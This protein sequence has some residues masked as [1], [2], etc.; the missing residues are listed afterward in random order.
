MRA[1]P[2]MKP[3]VH[4]RKKDDEL[5]QGAALTASVGFVSLRFV[6][7]HSLRKYRPYG[8][9]KSVETINLGLAPWAM[10]ECRPCRVL[11]R[12]HHQAITWAIIY[13]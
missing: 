12:F 7:L 8:A 6:D 1:K 9:Q 4:Q 13:Q 2:E 3:W 11:L 10:Q 5:R